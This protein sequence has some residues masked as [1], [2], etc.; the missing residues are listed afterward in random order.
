MKY[1]FQWQT[2]L[3]DDDFH[4]YKTVKYIMQ[5]ENKSFSCEMQEA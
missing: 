4:K 1:V 2:W 5:T 3:T